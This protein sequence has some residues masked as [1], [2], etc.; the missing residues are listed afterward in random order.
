MSVE[1]RSIFGVDIKPH[2]KGVGTPFYTNYKNEIFTRRERERSEDSNS[3]VMEG[4]GV[5]FLY[6]FIIFFIKNKRYKF[7][8]PKII[9]L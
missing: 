3:Q 4:R 7:R 5:L 8:V 6:S 1:F 9:Q 2:K